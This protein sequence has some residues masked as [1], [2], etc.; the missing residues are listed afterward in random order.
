MLKF[1]ARIIASFAVGLILSLWIVQNTPSVQKLVGKHIIKFLET[2]WRTSIDTKSLKINFFTGSLLFNDGTVLPSDDRKFAWHFDQ[3]KVDVSLLQLLMTKRLDLHLTFNNIKASTQH[4]NGHN[5]LTTHIQDIFAP[6]APKLNI[7]PQTITINNF[8]LTVKH[9]THTTSLCLPGAFSVVKSTQPDPNRPYNWQITSALEQATITYDN[10]LVVHHL[11][12]ITKLFKNKVTNEWYGTSA[13]TLKSPLIDRVETYNLDGTFGP[14]GKAFTLKDQNQAL[15]LTTT[16]SPENNVA[17]KGSFPVG[18][19]RSLAQ[20]V[21]GQQGHDFSLMPSTEGTCTVDLNMHLNQKNFGTSGSVIFSNL[22]LAN[23]AFQNLTLNLM[24]E[25]NEHTYSSIN[26]EQSANTHLTGSL[27]WD[28]EKGK[29]ELT[30]SNSLPLTPSFDSKTP[31]RSTYALQPQDLMVNIG[32]DSNGTISGTYKCVITHQSTEKQYSYKGALIVSNNKFGVQGKTAKG[33]YALMA[34]LTP[35]PHL[36]HWR[37]TVNNKH[38]IDLASCPKDP[39]T[40]KGTVAWSALRSCLDQS[41]KRLIFGNKSIFALTL[42]QESLDNMHGTLRLTD[43]RLYFPEYHNLIHRLQ[44]EVTID[45]QSKCILFDNVFVGLSKGSLHCPRATITLN[46]SYGINA[47]HVPLQINNIFVNW[48]RDFYGFAYGNL[49]LNKLP[50]G[51]AN[52]SGNIVVKKSLL[53]D[54]FF[55]RNSGRALQG[56]MNSMFPATQFPIGL[57]IKLTTEKPVHINMPSLQANASADLSIICTPHKDFGNTPHIA[58]K[59]TLQNGCLKFLHNKLNIQYG[60][61][62]FLE[63]QINDPIIDLIAKDRI[64]KYLVTLQATGSLQKPTILLES[65]PEL[66]EEQIIGLLLTGSENA[67]LQADLP[68]MLLQNLD[69]FLLS[70]KKMKSNVLV[71]TLSKTLKYVQIAPDFTDQSGKG[72]LR[73]SISVNLSDQLRA[74][75][76]KNLTKED[77]SAQLEY[78]LSDDINLKVVKDQRG[79]LGSEVEFRLKL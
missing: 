55:S 11:T 74:Q 9:G 79:E 69:S 22:K 16:I 43:G 77:F 78:Q 39:T 72:G 3:C 13:T 4:E 52:L 19:M 49:L 24:S 28:W 14:D 38:I 76:Q 45:T 26:L 2:E 36:T 46:D 70:N 57:D 61:I 37:Y 33:E 44:T 6:K 31:T 71:D 53:K 15:T 66:T 48:K 17:L 42:H 67:T 10:T 8:D 63:S 73:G 5:D 51:L 35:R 54:S 41:T 65:N 7:A 1:I 75:V 56:P 18:I 58:G 47:M 21:G 25:N 64:N 12:G 29:G 30:L 60:K 27:A 62:Q 32:F 20:N 68:F 59:I 50:D 23:L 34:A 40:I